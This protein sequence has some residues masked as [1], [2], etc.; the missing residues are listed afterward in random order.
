MSMPKPREHTFCTWVPTMSHDRVA[1]AARSA[2]RRRPAPCRGRRRSASS[3][4]WPSAELA[5]GHEVVDHDL[6]ELLLLP[7]DRGALGHGQVGVGQL[8]RRSRTRSRSRRATAGI[9]DEPPT[10]STRSMLVDAAGLG[11]LEHG[12]G[13]LD[14]ALQQAGGQLLELVAGDGDVGPVRRRGSTSTSVDSRL[15]SVCLASSA[16]VMRSWAP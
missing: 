1:S 3:M 12:P 14:R 16:A 13:Q 11:R 15:D 7:V 10:S 6:L 8:G 5:L 2:R 9:F 4:P